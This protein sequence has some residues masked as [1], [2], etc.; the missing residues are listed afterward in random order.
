[1][2]FSVGACTTWLTWMARPG[3]NV[4]TWP[5]TLIWTVVDV[6]PLLVADAPSR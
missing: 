2:N 3:T 6:L 1:M 4:G 5:V